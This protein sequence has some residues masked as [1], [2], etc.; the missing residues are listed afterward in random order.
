MSQLIKVILQLQHRQ[1][2]PTIKA[3]PLNPNIAFEQTPFYLQRQ[4]GEWRRPVLALDGG[5]PREYPLRATVSSFGAGGS[6]AHLIVEEYEAPS[7]PA[8]ASGP[9]KEPHLM[10]FSADRKSTRLNSSHLCASRMPSHAS[11]KKN[12][13]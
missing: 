10:L 13:P 1:L 9:A 8:P 7:P 3:Q 11:K 12:T 4:L 5:E 6:N 2:A